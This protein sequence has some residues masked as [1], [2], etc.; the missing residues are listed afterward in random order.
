MFTTAGQPSPVQFH[1][2]YSVLPIH[3]PSPEHDR[4]HWLGTAG[5][6]QNMLVSVHEWVPEQVTAVPSCRM[7]EAFPDEDEQVCGV[8]QLSR[9]LVRE[10]TVGQPLHMQSWG[11]DG[12]GPSCMEQLTA[13][14]DGGGQDLAKGDPEVLKLARLVRLSNTPIGRLVKAV[15]F[16]R[17]K[18]VRL[19]RLSNTPTGRLVRASLKPRCTDV[20]LVRLSNN[21]TGRRVR[22]AFPPR[23]RCLRLVKLSN[24][25]SGRLV[26]AVFQPSS[27]YVR[28]FRL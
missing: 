12:M 16:H 8:S 24:T 10:G 28:L 22:A 13:E 20:S 3:D 21:P 11:L 14:G 17:Y 7:M 19:V 23:S 26:K 9:V 5:R 27:K 4:L 25:P 18:Y 1:T 6:V 15:L 2:P